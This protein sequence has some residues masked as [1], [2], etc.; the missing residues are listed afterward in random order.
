MEALL[1]KQAKDFRVLRFFY[2]LKIKSHDF[3]HGCNYGRVRE[4]KRFLTEIRRA[5]FARPRKTGSFKVP[6]PLELICLFFC[7]HSSKA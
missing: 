3:H 6:A 7:F 5:G 4:T 2:L 1:K